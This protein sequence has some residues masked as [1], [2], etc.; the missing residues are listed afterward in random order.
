MA[1]PTDKE[2]FRR[3]ENQDIGQ[4]IPGSTLDQDDHNKPVDF[5]E[6]LQDTLGLEIQGTETSVA[7]RLTAIESKFQLKFFSVVDFADISFTTAGFTKVFVATGYTAEAGD[8]IF[9]MG[10]ADISF[11]TAPQS[12]NVDVKLKT[13]VTE[14]SLGW[15]S[16]MEIAVV[17]GKSRHAL[18]SKSKVLATGGDFSI[19][20]IGTG[21]TDG[22]ILYNPSF[23][24]LVFK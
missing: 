13:G 1:Y 15:S 21:A 24:F 18:G 17:A 14:Y 22:G 9:I 11:S 7:E 8:R 5:I 3:V 19:G 12:I 16:R 2:T 10:G 6:R 23:M 4:G 20:L